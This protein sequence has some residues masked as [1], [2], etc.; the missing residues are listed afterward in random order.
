M[1]NYEELLQEYVGVDLI[2]ALNTT[3]FEYFDRR[4]RGGRLWIVGKYDV[5][6]FL[7]ACGLSHKFHFAPNGGRITGHRSAWWASVDELPNNSLRIVAPIEALMLKQ[8]QQTEELYESKQHTIAAKESGNQAL[9]NEGLLPESVKALPVDVLS[10]SISPGKINQLKHFGIRSIGDLANAKC[11]NLTLLRGFGP[12]MLEKLRAAVGDIS[13]VGTLVERGMKAPVP[14]VCNM[15]M[16]SGWQLE[17]NLNEKIGLTSGQTKRLNEAGYCTVEDLHD[18]PT[19]R[20]IALKGIGAK[21]TNHIAQCLAKQRIATSVI[22]DVSSIVVRD[23]QQPQV[24]D[25]LKELVGDCYCPAPQDPVQ[26]RIDSARHIRNLLSDRDTPFDT[27]VE[28]IPEDASLPA[29]LAFLQRDWLPEEGPKYMIAALSHEL[30][31]ARQA[32]S[33]IHL[34]CQ[35][36]CDSNMKLQRRTLEIYM[37]RNGILGKKETL[38]EIADSLALT[39]ERVRQLALKAGNKFRPHQSRRLL[40]FRIAVF[41]TAKELGGSGPI[42]VL[43]E[44]I[45]SISLPYEGD[46]SLLFRFCGEI[47]LSSD[48]S[49]FWLTDYPC[50]TCAALASLRAHLVN[51]ESCINYTDAV[52]ELGC[53]SCPS[54]MRPAI[55]CLCDY[56]GL[57]YVDGL[58]GSKKNPTLKSLLKPN[59]KRA[60]IHAILFESVG[61]LTCD[62]V[63]C[64]FEKRTGETINKNHVASQIT[65]FD[66]C[67]LWGRGTYI[68]ERNVPNPSQLLD[69]IANYAKGIFIK[70]RVPIIG[71]GGLYESFEDA[72]VGAG[73]PTR[74]ALYSLL[75]KSDDEGLLLKE[76][77]WICDARTIGDRTSFAKYFYS[78]LAANN[79][80]ITDKHAAEIADRVMAQS[81]ALNGLAEYS[82]YLIN[83]N[84]GWYDIEAA[85]F[86]MDGIAQLAIE[87]ADNMGDDDIVSAKWAFNTY[88]ERCNACGVK[89]Y[90]ILYYLIDMMEDDLPIE[91]TRLP[92]LVKSKHEHS[93]VL[94]VARRY[95]RGSDHPVQKIELIDEFRIKRGINTAGLCTK[96][97]TAA[98][99]II[100]VDDETYWSLNKL[101]ID[102]SFMN[103]FDRAI[104][105]NTDTACKH[106]GLFYARSECMPL[107][108]KLPHLSD[109][110]RWSPELLSTV[111]SKSARF[112]TFGVD[113]NCIVNLSENPDV[114]NS[115]HF[116][117]SL[118][119]NEFM[120][121]APFDTFAD[122]CSMYSIKQD[123]EPEYFDAYSSIEADDVSIQLV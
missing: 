33:Y 97:L 56:D 40:L 111:F 72:L 82:Q 50:S 13:P 100:L 5:R 3:G 26:I 112:A 31:L 34:L 57:D 60:V 116:W 78:V 49:R 86:D 85:E 37:R 21:A 75:R 15:G 25:E 20:I 115:E 61:A 121:W 32:D 63:A 80:F 90:D 76:Y 117:I 99:D 47:Q 104:S 46:C 91:A 92:H 58:I 102:E 35:C 30:L 98:P 89:S 6:D 103:A 74:H 54:Q 66:D 71:V 24:D 38:Q 51:S 18:V 23:K 105:E 29:E 48:E 77:P 62:E 41:T 95:I 2:G 79:G 22:P 19:D 119:K 88:R 27:P 70:N 96:L 110:M 68:H 93:S 1:D 52:S 114:T 28:N 67:M 101:N 64:E 106:A 39:R 9:L 43:K 83:A 4:D 53:S 107:Y 108:E 94:D 73:V 55:E 11:D 42:E 65:S 120:G 17:L 118:L 109:S 14:F 8:K 122:Y 10:G 84:G 12:K 44:K 123:L 87:I 81:F 36:L 69:S 59:N 7:R 113:C 45:D 16:L